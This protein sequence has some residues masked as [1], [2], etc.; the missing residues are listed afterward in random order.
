MYAQRSITDLKQPLAKPH[1]NGVKINFKAQQM[2]LS[3]R[4]WL[5]LLLF[6]L[7]SSIFCIEKVK[8]FLKK[9]NA[10]YFKYFGIL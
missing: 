3:N 10:F 4:K 6:L 2:V 5:S 7:L 1:C 8:C 9:R